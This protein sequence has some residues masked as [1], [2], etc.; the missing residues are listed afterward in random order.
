M[1]DG[2]IPYLHFDPEAGKRFARQPIES[3]P[4]PAYH[5]PEIFDLPIFFIERVGGEYFLRSTLNSLFCSAIHNCV[6]EIEVPE[7]DS[8]AQ[9]YVYNYQ[10]EIVQKSALLHYL[11][12]DLE[13]GERVVGYAFEGKSK[14]FLVV[15]TSPVVFEQLDEKIKLLYNAARFLRK[16]LIEHHAARIRGLE[17]Q[18]THPKPKGHWQAEMFKTIFNENPSLMSDDEYEMIFG[19]AR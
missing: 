5:L 17:S 14:F 16:N 19:E 11:R 6:K 9:T 4:F 18:S 3:F 12:I 10:G 1:S 2:I 8:L 15:H 13:I 7:W